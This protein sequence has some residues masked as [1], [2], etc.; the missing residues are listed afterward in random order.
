MKTEPRR[1]GIKKIGQALENQKGRNRSKL[2]V[3]RG[4]LKSTIDIDLAQQR[5]SGYVEK[6]EETGSSSQKSSH[7]SVKTQVCGEAQ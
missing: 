7:F 3:F 6:D 4:A 1:N 2:Q 5:K